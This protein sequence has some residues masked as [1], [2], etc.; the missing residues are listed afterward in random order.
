MEADYQKTSSHLGTQIK[1]VL[2]GASLVPLVLVANPVD[3]AP[4]GGQIVGGSGTISQNN[5]TTHIKQNTQNLAIDW[6]SFNVN[7]NEIVNYLQPNS[8]SIAL[9]R[10]IGGSAS[11][12]HGQINA[13]GHVVLVNPNGVFFGQGATVN[14]GGLIASGLDIGTADFMNGNY[15]F[16]AV[17]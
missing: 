6:N 3:A 9:N 5:L 15:L 17:G 11:E 2:L 1:R 16:N 7:S 14:V 13:N 8:S 4:Q 12:I 10:I